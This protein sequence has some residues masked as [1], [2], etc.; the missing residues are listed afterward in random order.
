[1]SK[2]TMFRLCCRWCCCCPPPPLTEEK[3]SLVFD[4]CCC[5]E[6]EAEAWFCWRR[7]ANCAWRLCWIGGCC[8]CWC[9]CCCC[10]WWCCCC[11]CI[12]LLFATRKAAWP[13]CCWEVGRLSE[14]YA[15]GCWRKEPLFVEELLRAATRLR[16]S[17]FPWEKL[18]LFI[19]PW[20]M[21]LDSVREAQSL[22]MSKSLVF[23]LW[24][25][26]CVLVLM[27]TRDGPKA[28]SRCCYP[29]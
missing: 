29:L 2:L 22:C 21:W 15:D 12:E 24:Q 25:S 1:M 19:I 16:R 9:C 17:W 18:R 13:F 8:C 5:T 4:C 27:K 11:C 7:L 14:E 6:A 23:E 28:D 10:W 3:R 20:L 26:L